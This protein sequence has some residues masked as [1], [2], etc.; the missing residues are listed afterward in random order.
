MIGYI[1]F[2]I[3][4]S[5]EKCH[6]QDVYGRMYREFQKNILYRPT[7]VDPDDCLIFILFAENVFMI[8]FISAKID[9]FK[10]VR[11]TDVYIPTN[12]RYHNVSSVNMYA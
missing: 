7:I 3:I 1:Q 8:D 4:I 10:G 12:L 5:V 9:S 2:A 6:Y 11:N